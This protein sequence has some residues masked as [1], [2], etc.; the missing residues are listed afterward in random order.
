MASSFV[1]P[2][3]LTRCTS[4]NLVTCGLR[5]SSHFQLMQ[6]GAELSAC[7]TPTMQVLGCEHKSVEHCPIC[8][9]YY[10]CNRFSASSLQLLG[11]STLIFGEGKKSVELSPSG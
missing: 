3:K 2:T 7:A 11:Q 6:Q 4:V 9:N 5:Y 1:E 10:V 8:R